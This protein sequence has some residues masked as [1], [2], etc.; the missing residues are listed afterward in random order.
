M[1]IN[2]LE[3]AQMNRAV[4][5]ALGL[6]YPLI[7]SKNV[8]GID[9]IIGC[10]NHNPG[11]IT[12]EDL[13]NHF[14]A[15]SELFDE[16]PVTKSIVIKDNQIN[17]I[18]PKRGFSILIEQNRLSEDKCIEIMDKR[19]DEIADSDK[20]IRIEFVKGCFDGRSSWDTT[21]HYLSID[22]DRSEYRKEK[23]AKI[24]ESLAIHVNVNNRGVGHPKNDQIR[25][26]PDSMRYFL[27]T[28]GMYSTYRRQ[29][30]ENGLRNM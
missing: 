25:I 29:Q 23:I 9:Y 10:V 14:K 19:V 13:A 24:I 17:K 22:V 18:Q 16:Y 4:A 15:V 27:S 21:A 2:E 30:V 11:K 1:N 26:R 28:V 20:Q 12:D 7:K 8:D 3:N 5:Y 6:S